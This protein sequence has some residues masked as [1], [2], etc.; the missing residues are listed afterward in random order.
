MGRLSS[1]HPSGRLVGDESHHPGGDVDVGDLDRDA[2]ELRETAPELLPLLDVAGGQV[3]RAG[4]QPL[5]LE[6]E[7]GHG[8][9]AQDPG[10]VVS[11][12]SEHG[13]R[14]EVVRRLGA[15][16]RRRGVRAGDAFAG[17][18]DQGDRWSVGSGGGDDQQGGAVGEVVVHR[19][20]ELAAGDGVPLE[21]RRRPDGQCHPD[22]VERRG[23]E[24]VADDDTRDEDLLLLGGAGQ[25]Q[26]QQPAD[27]G[28]AHRQVERPGSHL[29]HEDGD[30]G[31]PETLA[32]VVRRRRQ[33]QQPGLGAGGPAR[34]DLGRTLVEHVGEHRPDL[35]ME[36]SRHVVAHVD[37]FVVR[38]CNLF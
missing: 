26:W 4:E 31:E 20:R 17:R 32:T 12:H 7:S 23:D 2:L 3:T 19:D 10:R 11:E 38:N 35:V 34:L 33:P 1:G 24:Q 14:V 30:L 28:L 13:C 27:Q 15:P 21:T 36:V 8:V 25:R 37:P 29:A 5:A 16:A 18:V 6:E 22:L 9:A